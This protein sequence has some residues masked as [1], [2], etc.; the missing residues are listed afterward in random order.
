MKYFDDSWDFKKAETKEYTHCFH[1]YPAMMIPQIA[2]RLLMQFGYNA[3]LLFDP[4]CGSGTSL[5]EATLKGVEAIGTEL[6]PLARLIATTKTTS[7]DKQILDSCL[8][9]FNNYLFVLMFKPYKM[10]PKLPH[11]Q[12][13]DYWFAS[14]I[15]K[16]LATIKQYIDEQIEDINI[17]NFF[18]V[19]FSEVI[20]ESSWIRKGEFKLS[21]MTV[22]Q[23]KYFQPDI[24]GLMQLKLAR[25]RQGL[26]AYSRQCH[27]KGQVF[28][29]N[30]VTQVP[31]H[32]VNN[33]DI[34]ITSPPYGDSRTT[35]AYGQFSRLSSQWL[36]FNQANQVDNLLMGGKL[37]NSSAPLKFECAMLNESIAK[38]A[39]KD[40]KRVKEVIAFYAD[41]EKSIENVAKTIKEGG[42]VCYVVGNRRV[43]GVDLPTDELTKTAFERNGFK[44]IETI[45]RNI[46]N[47]RMPSKNS[48]S[49]VAGKIDKTM[50]K[51]YIVV[52]QKL[53]NEVTALYF[54][55]RR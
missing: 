33:I 22:A 20:R 30:T 39:E 47:K 6:N 51:E 7:L 21:R 4:Y 5:V 41:Y 55:P 25:N 29:F 28:S 45:I 40:Q 2:R 27:A 50:T 35:V 24:F 42:Y 31:K 46:P 14:D 48:P 12:N 3:R 16:K 44:H 8:K 49:N 15:Q 26:L 19:A 53:G 13:I 17:Q 36:G 9:K 52:L 37:N 32:L 43:K 23:R 38:I 10:N 11:F 18:K 54:A 34:V 1:N